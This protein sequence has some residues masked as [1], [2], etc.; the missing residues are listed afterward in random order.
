MRCELFDI[1]QS[2][3]AA[4]EYIA[5]KFVPILTEFWK[6]HG[7][8]FYGAQTWSPGM[9]EGLYGMIN[10]RILTLLV[11]FGDGDE[12]VGFI[13]GTPTIHL[14][15]NKA[16]FIV[17]CWYGRD[18]AVEETLF[19]NLN[20]GLRYMKTDRILIPIY[21][22]HEMPEAAKGMFD[23]AGTDRR[24]LSRGFNDHIS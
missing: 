14:L 17:E 20:Q 4:A 8:A 12:P 19:K 5:G 21:E 2:V 16:I 23:A 7:A 22:G 15:T 3:E 9:V 13:L 18:K 24:Y 11:A 1:R 10:Q 6:A